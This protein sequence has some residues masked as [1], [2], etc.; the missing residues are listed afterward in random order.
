[1]EKQGIIFL[2]NPA[3]EV[4]NKVNQIAKLEKQ[5]KIIDWID[6]TKNNQVGQLGAI[7]S[8]SNDLSGVDGLSENDSAIVSGINEGATALQTRIDGEH[9]EYHAKGAELRSQIEELTN[10]INE[11]VSNVTGGTNEDSTIGNVNADQITINSYRSKLLNIIDKEEYDIDNKDEM[12]SQ[13]EQT[14]YDDETPAEE[15][16]EAPT[17]APTEEPTEAPTE[18][19]TEEPTEAPT[20]EAGE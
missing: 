12:I 13:L 20:E 6:S 4:A 19:P 7:I 10:D 3:Q 18:A 14:D 9:N 16:T 2:G 17:E 5:Y 11:F 1:M 8:V 15:P